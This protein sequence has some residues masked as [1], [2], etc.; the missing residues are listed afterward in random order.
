MPGADAIAPLLALPY[1]DARRTLLDEFELRYLQS[2]LAK[3]GGNVRQ[4]ARDAAMDRTYLTE[5]L[6]RHGLV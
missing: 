5:L 1:K 6:K 4:A 3:T 2:L